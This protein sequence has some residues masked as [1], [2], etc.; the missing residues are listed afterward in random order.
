MR[1]TMSAMRSCGAVTPSMRFEDS[2]LSI[3]AA[4]WRALRTWGDCWM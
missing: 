4:C 1:V 2:V 3:W